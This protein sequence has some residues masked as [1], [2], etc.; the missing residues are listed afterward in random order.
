M[1]GRRTLKSPLNQVRL[2]ELLRLAR[3]GLYRSCVLSKNFRRF[4][5]PSARGGWGR[6]E[7]GATLG[8]RGG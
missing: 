2:T 1:T 8:I 5:P 7:A 3:M 6:N 4:A